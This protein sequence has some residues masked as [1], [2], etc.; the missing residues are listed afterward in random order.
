MGPRKKARMVKQ[1]KRNVI[2]LTVKQNVIME[3]NNGVPLKKLSKKFNISISTIAGIWTNR[4]KIMEK[5][6]PEG[7]VIIAKNRCEGVDE[8]ENKLSRWAKISL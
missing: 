6:Y 8:V 1:V 7:T 5:R 4:A 2:P 3:K